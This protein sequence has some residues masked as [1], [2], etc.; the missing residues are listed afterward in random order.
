[1]KII[2]GVAA[3]VA[4]AAVMPQ[5]AKANFYSGNEVYSNCLALRSDDTYYQKYAM[6]M[7]YVSGAYDAIELARDIN[8]APRC[9]PDGL[10]V[11]QLKDVVVKYMREHPENRN[12]SAASLVLLSMVDA[13]GCS[14][15]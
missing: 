6:C 12:Y 4:L 10:T 13:W 11:G 1:M 14:G 9:G 15:K 3:A 8:S 2:M 5:Q 7:A